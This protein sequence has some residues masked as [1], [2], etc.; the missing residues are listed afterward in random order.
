MNQWW[1]EAATMADAKCKEIG[2]KPMIIHSEEENSYWTKWVAGA[3]GPQ[4]VLPLVC[5]ENTKKWEWTDG[6]PVDYKPAVYYKELDAD[7]PTGYTWDFHADGSWG[8]GHAHV[9]IVP[10][11]CCKTQLPPLPV[12]QDDECD[13][14]DDDSD[15]AVCYKIAAPAENFKEA[16][17]ICRSFGAGL[18]SVHSLQENSFIRRLAVSNGH[19]KGMFLGAT[20]SGKGDKFGWMDGHDLYF[21]ADYEKCFPI[22]GLAMDTEGTSGYWVNTDCSSSLSV[23]CMRQQ[24]YVAPACTSGI[25]SEGEIVLLLEA[26]SCCDHLILFDNYVAGNVIANL[27]G[28][29][30][31]SIYH[32]SPSNMMRVSW[33]PNG[34]VNVR[35]MMLKR[36]KEM[37]KQSNEKDFKK[38]FS[39]NVI[40]VSAMPMMGV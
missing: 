36:T 38:C 18:A 5:N 24:N 4:M 40:I 30:S 22:K 8:V 7:C 2:G 10:D 32:T 9:E 23:A 6:S 16:Q 26:N 33:Q 14:F 27:T 39:N 34:G 25:Y 15:D 12:Q 29:I 28:E 1:D 21:S 3:G 19:V 37:K 35:G 17:K 13:G 20:I 11:I 31:V